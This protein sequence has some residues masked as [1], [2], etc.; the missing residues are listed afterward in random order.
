MPAILDHK[1]Y[2]YDSFQSKRPK[3]MRDVSGCM[4]VDHCGRDHDVKIKTYD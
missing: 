2:K 3:S 4:Y 1:Q